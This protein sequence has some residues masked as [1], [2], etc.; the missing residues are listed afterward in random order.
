MIKPHYLI[1]ASLLLLSFYCLF[2]LS[3]GTFD[4]K[5][6]FAL[7]TLFQNMWDHLSHGSLAVDAELIGNEGF[8]VNGITTAYFLPFPSL[9][10]GLLS[11]A[12]LGA[13]A[14]LSL[15]LGALT[16]FIASLFI[17]RHFFLQLKLNND[18]SRQYIWIFGVLLCTFFSPMI[19]MMAYPTAFWEAIV[20][21]SALFLTASYLSITLLTERNQKPAAFFIFT[22][23]CGLALFTRAT[24]SFSTCLLYGITIIQ[25]LIF[26]WKKD[27]SITDN[28]FQNKS[29]VINSFF[30]GLFVCCLLIFNFAKWGNPFEFYPL[31]H[32][33]MWDEAK[34]EQYFSHG[35]LNPTRLPE[36]L[37]YYFLPALDNFSLTKPFINLGSAD[38]LGIT[39]T[40]DYKEHTLPISITQP[41]ATCFFILG[42]VLLPWTLCFQENKKIYA[43]LPA[44]L[45]AL[46]PII[47]I[48]SIHS[49]SI[50]YTGDFLPAFMLF[51]LFALFQISQF[52]KGSSKNLSP[53]N[54]FIS[55]KP[56]IFSIV[57]LGLILISLFV[58]TAGIFRQNE[59]W[60]P[61][62][63]YSL[64]PLEE[65]ETVS[66]SQH[67][68]NSKGVGYLHKGWASELE[69]FG[70]WSN[71]SAPTL[72]ILPPKTLSSKNALTI[73]ARAFVAPNHP[74]QI[75]EVW[76]NGKLNQ[77]VTLRDANSNLILI[78]PLIT[79]DWTKQNWSYLGASLFNK[80]TQFI[81]TSNQE[82]IVIQFHLQ[83]P[84]RPSELGLSSDSRL[85]GIGLISVT[86]Q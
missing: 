54:K 56:F 24:F 47:L 51:G 21:A 45:S 4:L 19:G 13:S 18:R 86:L 43:I 83:N 8:E 46:V 58:S 3:L 55:I 29:L 30:F 72:M 80:L 85:L 33:K 71:T 66:F 59:A 49:L 76:V 22:F 41:I 77:T 42:L 15:W 9:V 81:G 69:S 79:S 67:G 34:K 39:G 25:I 64:I 2:L 82:A 7:S 52:I 70:T 57:M 40:F 23:I 14:V 35:A 28:I 20:W 32:Y 5:Q 48:L 84:A 1:S 68:N 16:F 74:E 75:V 6:P 36:T 11:I 27:A 50:R 63:H 37:S 65:G 31:E 12:D 53:P 73:L 10:R 38:H 62:F 78:K 60:R 61:V 26:Q 17:W 44:A